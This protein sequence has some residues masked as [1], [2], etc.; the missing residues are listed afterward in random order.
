MRSNEVLFRFS[1]IEKSN[2]IHMFR[3][4]NKTIQARWTGNYMG[5]RC[6]DNMVELPWPRFL[7]RGS[8]T[9]GEIWPTAT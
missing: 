5:F 6:S 3:F 7:R 1:G 2:V 8:E 9:V 4:D